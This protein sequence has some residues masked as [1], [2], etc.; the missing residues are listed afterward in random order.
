MGSSNRHCSISLAVLLVFA[1]LLLN[2]DLGSCGCFK[3]IFSFGDSITDTGNFAYISR[4]SPPGPPSV[5]SYGETYFHRPTGRAS[6]GRLIIDFYGEASHAFMC[7]PTVRISCACSIWCLMLCQHKR[8][9]CRCC[10][11]A[12]PRRRRGS[13]RPVPTLPFLA[14]LRP[15]PRTSCQG[16][17][18]VCSAGAS[19]SSWLLSR[20]CSHG[21]LQE[22]VRNACK[23]IRYSQLIIF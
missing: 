17:T 11:R 14:L 20:E 8:W 21:L 3:R 12:F 16:T 2:A 19:T 18:S 22:M 5:P 4:N 23:N 13:S 7:V 10:R 9:A 1:S 15:T 6:D